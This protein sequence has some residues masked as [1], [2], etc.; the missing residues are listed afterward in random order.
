MPLGE[1]AENS[2]K[3]SRQRTPIEP[4]AA[5]QSGTA[6]GMRAGVTFGHEYRSRGLR[7][8]PGA[9]RHTL[10]P[11]YR[12]KMTGWMTVIESVRTWWRRATPA[13]EG[14][15]AVFPIERRTTSV[16]AEYQALHTYLEHRYASIVVLTFEQMEAL[17]G[18]ALP[19]PACTEREWWTGPAVRTNRYS[20]AWMGAGRTATP[21]LLAR[22]VTFERLP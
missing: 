10:P 3:P 16:P 19:A 18:F 21:N 5:V 20:E 4:R 22:T 9:F 11:W 2:E 7:R 8:A 13:S 12:L 1:R 15:P 17:L 14:P 6:G